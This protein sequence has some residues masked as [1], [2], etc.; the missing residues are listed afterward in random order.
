MLFFSVIYKG[1]SSAKRPTHANA[2]VAQRIATVARWVA[3]EAALK[4]EKTKATQ[5]LKT[6]FQSFKQLLPPSACT[7]EMNNNYRLCNRS[8]QCLPEN[9]VLAKQT[10]VGRAKGLARRGDEF[11]AASHIDDAELLYF[12]SLALRPNNPSL[13]RKLG[14]LYHKVGNSSDAKLCYLGVVPDA[15]NARFFDSSKIGSCAKYPTECSFE[16]TTSPW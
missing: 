16:N 3:V 15:A 14:D 10:R 2:Q 12:Q 13:L 5:T 4:L 7:S 1:F 6:H 9:T 8:Q 11:Y